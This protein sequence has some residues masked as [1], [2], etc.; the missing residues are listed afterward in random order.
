[1]ASARRCG[2]SLRGRQR[3]P[4]L[5][6]GAS[7]LRDE[8]ASPAAPSIESDYR[9]SHCSVHDKEMTALSIWRDGPGRTAPE[10]VVAIA[11]EGML[12]DEVSDLDPDGG[13]SGESGVAAEER[14][15]PVSRGPSQCRGRRNASGAATAMTRRNRGPRG[16]RWPARAEEQESRFD[17]PGGAR[18]AHD[19][20]EEKQ[21]EGREPPRP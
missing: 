17:Q 8:Q 1:M 19:E 9:G 3:G 11:E 7:Q 15:E 2:R 13:A 18:A 21:G 20:H 5:R 16:G 4:S 6:Q 14:S 12:D 10:G